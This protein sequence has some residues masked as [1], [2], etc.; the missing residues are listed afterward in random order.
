MIIGCG[1]AGKTTLAYEIGKILGIDVTH[2]DLLFW[3]PGWEETEK[4]KWKQIVMEISLRKQWIIDGNY[5]STIDMRLST[6][7]TI[8]F[9][10]MTRYSCLWHV[11]KRR[12]VFNGRTRP[13]LTKGCPERLSWSFIKWIWTFP[14]LK[15]PGLLE[16]LDACKN[17]KNVIILQSG[18][19]VKS[20]LENLKQCFKDN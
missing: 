13:D 5:G 10:D 20:F 2:L 9:L 12:I 19:E 17:Q 8:I 1:G 4:L 3:K 14:K 18:K 15:R 6:A 7:D 11:F 16:K